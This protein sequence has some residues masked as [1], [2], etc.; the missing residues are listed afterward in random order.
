MT[1]VLELKDDD[2]FPESHKKTAQTF[3]NMLQ[4]LFDQQI[5]SKK[6]TVLE[7]KNFIPMF[8]VLGTLAAAQLNINQDEYYAIVD[9]YI[10]ELDLVAGEYNESKSEEGSEG[11]SDES[12]SAV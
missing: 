4:D 11:N 2:Y 9:Y 12:E 3:I 1:D 6:C 8:A 7:Y 5:K 10:K